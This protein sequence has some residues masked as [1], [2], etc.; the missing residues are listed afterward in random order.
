[1][2]D[3]LQL[4]KWTKQCQHNNSEQQLTLYLA[5]DVQRYVELDRLP[6]NV[7]FGGPI[8]VV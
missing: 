8:P 3:I 1:M 2:N 6:V 7:R 4:E 5:E